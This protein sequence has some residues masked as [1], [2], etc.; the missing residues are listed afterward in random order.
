MTP[1]EYLHLNQPRLSHPARTLYC[2]H[3]RRQALQGGPVRLAYPEL[4]RALAVEDPSLPGGFSYQVNA[5]QLTALLDE[6]LQAGLLLLLTPFQ[7][8]HYH[9][10]EVALPLLQHQGESGG[11]LPGQ[12]FPMQVTWRPD[13]QFPALAT[14]C[15]LLDCHYGEEELG[16]FIAYWLG[17]PESFATQHQWML[18]F[19]KTLKS[20]RYVR[21]TAVEAKG[22]QQVAVTPPLSGPSPR[23]LQ[24]IAEAER[25]GKP[26]PQAPQGEEHE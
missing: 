21:R 13:E 16:E 2:L 1:A 4:G 10:A 3:L 8:E 9:Q 17:R 6:L 26:V 18:K 12:A 20:R 15:G 7:G 11:P 25:L 5:R 14:L 24:M 19:I 23:A 22:Y